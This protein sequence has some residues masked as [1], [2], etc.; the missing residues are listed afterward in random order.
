MIIFHNDIKKSIEDQQSAALKRL[1]S[2][3][4]AKEP[5]LVYFLQN[6]WNTQKKAITYKEIRLAIMNGELDEKTIAEWQQDYSNFVVEHLRPAYAAAMEAATDALTAKYPNFIFNGM[7]DEVK[8]WTDYSAAMFVTNSSDVQIEAIRSVVGRAATLQDM[9]VDELSKVIRPMVGL[10]VPQANANLR[11]YEA[12]IASGMSAEKAK[13][14]CIRYSARQSRQRGYLIATTELAFAYNQGEF[15]GIKQAQQDGYMGH[16]EKVWSTADDE[17]VCDICGPLD[18]KRIAMND[19]FDFP[20]KLKAD[21]P[22]IDLV[23]PAHPR[24]RCGVIYDEVDP[25]E[26]DQEPEPMEESAPQEPETAIVGDLK[27]PEGL[28]YQGQLHGGNTGEIQRY[29]DKDGQEWF[30]KPAQDKSG[31]EAPFRA[32]VQ[33]AGYKVQS[34]I[35][36]DSAVPIGTFDIDGTFGA[37]QKRVVVNEETLIDFQYGYNSISADIAQQLQREHVTDWLMANYD[38]HYKNFLFDTKGQLVGVDKEQAFRF[39]NEAGAKKMGYTYHPNKM[40]GENE[41]IYNVLYKKFAQGDI[42]LNLNDAL[43]FIKRVESISD[44]EYR[45]IFRKYAE[46]LYDEPKAVNQL[47]D[48]IVERKA[49]LRETYREFYQ[50]LLHERTGHKTAFLFADEGAGA[51]KQALSAVQFDFDAAMKMKIV[52]LKQIAKS[53]SIPLYSKMNKQQLAKAISDP[54]AVPEVIQEIKLQDA[55]KKQGGIVKPKST[56]KVTTASQVFDDLSILPDEMSGMPIYSDHGKVE[57]LNIVGRNILI[58]NERFYEITGKLTGEA[59]DRTCDIFR[60]LPDTMAHTLSFE[61]GLVTGKRTS[62]DAYST[63]YIKQPTSY[64][65][66]RGDIIIDL[67][68]DK[69]QNAYKGFFRIRAPEGTDPKLI[70]DALEEV[71]L[72]FIRQNPTKADEDLFK[73]SRLLWNNDPKRSGDFNGLPMMKRQDSI[74]D[75]LISIGLDPKAADKLRLE[76]VFDNYVTFVNDDAVKEYKKAGLEYIWSGVGSKEAVISMIDSGG[77]IASTNRI[78]AGFKGG[79][80]V[81]TDIRRGGAE[82]VFTRIATKGAKKEDKVYSGSFASGSYQIIIDPKITRRTDWYAYTFDNYGDATPDQL[83]SRLDNLS[84][85]KSQNEKFK[86][87][88][89]LMF[90][91]G[92]PVS[93]WIG[94]DTDSQ[95]NKDQLIDALNQKGITLINGIPLDKFIRVNKIVGVPF[96]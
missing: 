14:R 18:G 44:K 93:E 4:N 95:F 48:T 71:N 24:C 57:D 60:G 89:E 82:S 3:L 15:M 36:P 35:D 33:E 32:H 8:Q 58:E 1:H 26:Y 43:P 54:A 62:L 47:L 38:S 96:K 12:M 21:N 9:S 30:F 83:A 90:R 92:I 20:S 23:P 50:D 46:S 19:H 6:M 81:D 22:S 56:S 72:S 42:D 91:H 59:W 79:S 94:I 7:A 87:D 66:Q 68:N 88:N 16:V 27:R 17:R 49:T 11:Y 65:W 51:A 85:V 69:S 74:D 40:Y 80:S 78:K 37:L 61:E 29:T 84:F 25:P 75:I 45:E 63:I 31:K 52:E 73:K 53:N 64:R 77:M 10:N 67:S 55:L 86:P 70:K 39:I 13:E 34:I 41:P 5:E 76:K 2:F 28:S